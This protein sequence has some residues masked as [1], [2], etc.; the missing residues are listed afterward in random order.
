MPQGKYR[1]II[2]KRVPVGE[3]PENYDDEMGG[4]PPVKFQWIV[5]RKYA[6][7]ETSGLEATVTSSGLE[8]NTFDI[9]TDGA[10]PEI[11]I[12]GGSG[13]A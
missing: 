13:G 7:S 5:P 1:V 3:L 4:G 2:S 8:P 10:A 12:V 6:T 11:E 9:K